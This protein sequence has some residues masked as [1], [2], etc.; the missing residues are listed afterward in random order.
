MDGAII[1]GTN[2]AGR[3]FSPPSA[4]TDIRAELPFTPTAGSHVIAAWVK[5]T[6]AFTI[7]ARADWPLSFIIE[8]S[9]RPN[10]SNT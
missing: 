6:A 1:D 7:A 4:G 10:A 3:V 9:V 2:I 8:E 5:A